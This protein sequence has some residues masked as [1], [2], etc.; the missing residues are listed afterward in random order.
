MEIFPESGSLIF[1][2]DLHGR[3]D[4]GV[5]VYKGA[6]GLDELHAAGMLEHVAADGATRASGLERIMNHG[7]DVAGGVHDRAAG[8]DDGDAAAGNNIGEAGLI[9][10]VG[11]LDDIGA[12]FVA[13]AGAVGDDF[14]IIGV[15]DFGTAAVNH[16]HERHPPVVAG[17]ADAAEVIQH[18]FF[19]GI[20][21]VDV[22][23]HGVSAVADGFLDGADESLVVIA[24]GEVCGSGEVHDEADVIA[25][26]TAAAADEALVHEDG[27]GAAFGEVVDGLLHVEEAVDGA[28]GYAVIHGNDD[29]VAGITVENALESNLFA[30]VHRIFS[31]SPLREF[32]FVAV[33]KKTAGSFETC[34]LSFADFLFMGVSRAPYHR[35]R[36]H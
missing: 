1:A 25:L 20:T 4:V 18:L 23:G 15:L 30:K 6:H 29:G 28:H 5:V 3:F 13:E 17:L 34:G 19:L 2:H 7:D 8:D 35:L 24:G 27:V 12:E 22:A 16:D 10:G 33:N 32:V 31:L 14:G 11:N 21:D 36:T 9:A 26:V